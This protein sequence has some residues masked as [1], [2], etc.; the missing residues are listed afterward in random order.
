MFRNLLWPHYVCYGHSMC[1]MAILCVFSVQEASVKATHVV[2]CRSSSCRTRRERSRWCWLPASMTAPCP[3][4]APTPGEPSL[5]DRMTWRLSSWDIAL[6]VRTHA[7]FLI[8][9]LLFTSTIWLW[10]DKLMRCQKE[11]KADRVKFKGK[12]TKCLVPKTVTVC[13]TESQSKM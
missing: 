2:C 1:V 6:R 13:T 10:K 4:W 9:Y 5:T 11:N 12:T 7:L 8:I 3:P